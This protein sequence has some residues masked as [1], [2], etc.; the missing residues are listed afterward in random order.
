MSALPPEIVPWLHYAAP[1][2]VGAFIGYLTNRVAIRML[3]RPL[4]RWRL[5]GIRVPMTPGVIPA[6][7]HELARNMGEVVGDHLLTS[8][9]I[10]RGLEHR[11]FQEH[12]GRLI[13]DKVE[14]VMHQELG[15][16][17]SLVP[18]KFQVYF[19]LGSQALSYQLKQQ[20]HRVLAADTLR[21][22]LAEAVDQQL[23]RLLAAEVDSILGVAA[24]EELYR[25]LKNGIDAALAE[26]AVE[27]WLEDFV[28]GRVYT[29]LQQ[30]KALADLLPPYLLELIV[31][32]LE[33][34]VPRFL[35]QL[36]G[37]I[38]EEEI[39][40]RIVRGVCGAVQSFV[41]SM[42][43]MAEM[44]RGFVRMDKVEE[45]VGSY[46]I[47]HH[48]EIV[49]WLTSVE[50]QERVVTILRTRSESFFARP[51]VTMVRAEDEEQVNAFCDK[52]C[53]H[54]LRLLRGGTVTS[55][56]ASLV[57]T[58]LEEQLDA[59]SATVGEAVTRLGGK[60]ILLN[61][62]GWLQS[63]AGRL[64]KAE[65]TR[66]GVGAL[67]DHLLDELANR[68]IGRLANLLPGGVREDLA[69]SLQLVASKM[70]ASEVPGLVQSL[71]IRRIVTDRINALDLLKLEG[72]LL[73]IMAD[74]FKYINLFGALLG[75]LIGCLNVLVL[76]GL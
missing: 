69:N 49:A 28:R 3:F 27:Q 33:R 10:G 61:G 51:I 71:N 54:V 40:Q 2:L 16:L 67:V 45:K 4:K 31:G 22:M 26:P 6:K 36:A 34:Q 21:T 24:R 59:G 47:D 65:A 57:A 55:A 66:R 56:I 70:L 32:T 74:Q 73:S 42:G 63:E 15:T 75:F 20:V 25:Q 38:G 46:L 30:E 35:G 23:D 62:R 13:R 64:L 19:S 58:H 7:R 9:E 52:T 48:D 72:L 41:N 37:I 14:A 5:A 44:V 50:V 53:E 29:I 1:P 60:N 43:S 11:V 8:A 39:R 76:V 18:L 68:K 17:K 12:L